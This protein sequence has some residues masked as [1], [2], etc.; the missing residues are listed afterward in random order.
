MK[1]WRKG[2]RE[3]VERKRGTSFFMDMGEGGNNGEGKRPVIVHQTRIS[4]TP[5]LSWIKW[6]YST[7]LVSLAGCSE[8]VI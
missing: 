8:G 6:Q 7:P 3:G 2:W 1:G 5:G 4:I